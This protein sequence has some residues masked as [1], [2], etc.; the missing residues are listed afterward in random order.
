M[1]LV[2][3]GVFLATAVTAGTVTWDD[4][5]KHHEGAAAQ[6]AGGDPV[7]TN[8]APQRSRTIVVDGSGKGN[9]RTIAAAIKSVPVGNTQRIIM[10][11][12]NGVYRY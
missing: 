8:A 2:L 11:I 3:A 4:F 7:V 10:D 12:R 9:F 6:G 5:I 1:V